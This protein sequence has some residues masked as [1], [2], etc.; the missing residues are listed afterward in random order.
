MSLQYD[1]A[2]LDVGK[3]FLEERGLLDAFVRFV[4]PDAWRDARQML[5]L[6]DLVLDNLAPRDEMWMLALSTKIPGGCC[7]GYQ[8]GV[9]LFQLWHREQQALAASGSRQ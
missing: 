4:V 5:C 3:T 9:Y 2:E 1:D 7:S 8:I 6:D